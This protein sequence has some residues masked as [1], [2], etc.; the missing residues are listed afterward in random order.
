MIKSLYSIADKK[1]NIYLPPFLAHNDADAQRQILT[2]L[3]KEQNMLSMYPDDYT[4][5]KIGSFD[6]SKGLIEA[7]SVPTIIVNL[8]A[9]LTSLKEKQ[10]DGNSDSSRT[11]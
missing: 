7:T 3:Q 5:T 9:L 10:N 4:L 6:D 1:S 2:M 8:D 11:N